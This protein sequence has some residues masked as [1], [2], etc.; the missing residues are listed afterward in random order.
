MNLENL[1]VR[2]AAAGDPRG[3]LRQYADGVILDEAQKVPAL[4]SYVQVLVDE[5]REMGKFVFTG[6]QNFLLM[7]SIT[8]S[9]AGRAGISHLLPFTL[10]ECPEP[11]NP[12]VNRRMLRGAYP[13]IYDRELAPQDFYPSYLETY[14]ERDVQS[15]KNIGNLGLFRKFLL[16]CAGRS[17]Q[18][19]NLTSLGNEVGVD[20]KTIQSWISV[21]ETGFLVYRLPPYYKN[22]NKRVV[23]QPK[24]YFLDTGI[25]CSLLGIRKERDLMSHPLRGAIFETMIVSETVKQYWHRG[26]RPP[27]YF[28]RDHQG[29]EIDLLVENADGLRAVEVKSGETVMPSWFDGLKWFR[30]LAGDQIC[31]S[32]LVYGGSMDMKQDGFP[33]WPWNRVQEIFEA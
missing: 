29:R 25:L 31:S 27:L 8:Q 21:L 24:L 13:P 17:G 1:D 32:S 3:F 2:E 11:S 7:E 28:W 4:F 20:H 12:Q 19:L 18:I 10:D 33:V 9:L 14:V 16:L 30:D 6:S 22:R 23:K 15:L 26:E 5:I